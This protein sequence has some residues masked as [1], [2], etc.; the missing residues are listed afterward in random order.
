MA[1]SL[2]IKASKAGN[3][4]PTATTGPIARDP[5]PRIGTD[6]LK[7]QGS[8]A[9]P[10]GGLQNQD[11]EGLESL[12]SGVR[13]IVL[14][15]GIQD[16]QVDAAKEKQIKQNLIDE[17]H[18]LVPGG[19]YLT[20][21]KDASWSIRDLTN[22]Y[23]I[24]HAMPPGDRQALGG[25]TFIRAHHAQAA[26]GASEA[27]RKQY[28]KDAAG[29]L[30]EL[31]AGGESHAVEQEDGRPGFFGRL[32]SGIKSGFVHA[33]EALEGFL[34][35]RILSDKTREAY[36]GRPQRSIILTDTGSNLL[37]SGRIWAHEIG[38]QLQLSDGRWNPER[39]REFS[40]LSGWTETYPVGRSEIYD[41]IDDRTGRRMIFNDK[42]VKATRTDNFVSK[43]AATDPV[44]DFAESYSSYL[45]NPGL[46]LQ[47]APEK[48]LFINAESKKYS[49]EQVLDLARKANVDLGRVATALVK[50]GALKQETLNKILATHDLQPNRKEVLADLPAGEKSGLMLAWGR[51]VEH[52][53]ANPD[54]GAAIVDDPASVIGKETWEKL[55]DQDRW[56]LANKA[57]MHKMVGALGKGW[58]GVK[59]ATEAAQLEEYRGGT[60]KVLHLLLEDAVFRN[61]LVAH[62]Q[63]TLLNAGLA[64]A[65]PVDV[66]EALCKEENRE[67]LKNLVRMLNNM[68]SNAQ[69]WERYQANIRK[70]SAQMGP[71]HFE[72]FA[73]LLNDRKGTDQAAKVLENA[74]KTGNLIFPGD[75]NSPP[76]G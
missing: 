52:L 17:I 31:G 42:I 21:G 58:A 46:L 36:D 24:L 20:A 63:K 10:P 44:E 54:A 25:V 30:E 3:I 76:G 53:R 14:T 48:F 15:Y 12:S 23:N 50:E 18:K 2:N 73:E 4:R 75:G 64:G 26:D 11:L 55:I 47:R 74:I 56:V 39:I 61:E 37:V 69:D 43:Y 5:A 34:H 45:L 51:I 68:A 6:T 71:D 32:A 70:L 57:F 13:Q 1:D 33:V 29:L 28:G 41:G 72:A 9:N 60:D 62:P 66:T 67:A 27:V 65:L 59:S 22:L 49:T 19:V 16:G 35:I 38:H 8:T 40:K 7:T